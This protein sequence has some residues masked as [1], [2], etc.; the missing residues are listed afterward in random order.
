M[1]FHP[2]PS[3][4]PAIY[5]FL[6]NKY[7]LSFRALPLK[8]GQLEWICCLLGAQCRI[9]DSVIAWVLIPAGGGD[10]YDGLYGEARRKR[11][12]FF[13]LQVYERVGILLVEVYERPVE[14]SVIWVSKMAQRAEQMN[15]MAL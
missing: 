9:F 10:P 15:F 12:T 1:P 8:T 11:G 4:G 7:A 2:S 13:R 5:V 14:K 6:V 3:R